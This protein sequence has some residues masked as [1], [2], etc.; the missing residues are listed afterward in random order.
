M[1]DQNAQSSQEKL[2]IMLVDDHQMLIDGIKSL[3]RK[4]KDLEFVFEANDGDEAYQYLKQHKGA[5]DLVL[6]DIRMPRVD[7]L[8]LT[9]MIKDEMPEIKVLVLSMFNDPEI[10]NK[11]LLAEAEGYVLKNTGKDE[12]LEA[13]HRIADGGSFYSSEV[14][15]SLMRKRGEEDKK[16]KREASEIL[17]PREIEIVRL[18]CEELTTAEIADKLF[19]SPRTVDTHRKNILEKTN[20]RSIVSLIKFAYECELIK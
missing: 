1:N 4:E 14:I 12:L 3:L 13:I 17:T 18:I 9:S 5:V 16:K 11:I 2:K 8:E 7:G 19:I 20:S 6:T 10:V 15:A